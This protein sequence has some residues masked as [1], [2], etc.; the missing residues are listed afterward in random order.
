[1]LDPAIRNFLD[2]RRAGWLKKRINNSTTD[3]E[4]ERI[5]KQAN[6]EYSLNVWL[7]NAAK[8]AKQLSLV[9]H[10]SKFSHP[11]ARTTNII[12][13]GQSKTDGLLRTGNIHTELDVLGNAAA[14]DVYKFLSLKI[15]D[16]NTILHHL[17]NKTDLIKK[18]LDVPTVP[19]SKIEQGLLAIKQ[20]DDQLIQTSDKVKQVYF[21]ITHENEYHLLSI[22]TPSPI[23]FA[24]KERI[25]TMHFSETAKEARENKKNNKHSDDGLSEIYGLS[26][27]GYGGTKPQN[28]S[29]L[30]N[31]NYGEA[32]LLPSLPPS[33]SNRVVHPPRTDFFSESLKPKWFADDFQTFHSLLISDAN[34]IHIRRKRDRT[35]K[36]IISKVVDRL[37]SIR[38]LE[39]GWS[40]SDNYQNLP[41]NQKIW[42]DQKYR[43]T[44]Q[45][46]ISWFDSI[47]SKLSRWFGSAYKEII[48]TKAIPLGDDLVEHIQDII[49]K[50]EGGLI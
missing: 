16:G 22:L 33:L 42:L 26:V 8:R 36:S 14:L 5:E 30:N 9:S 25:R 44:R 38:Y 31:E 29:V 43:E 40:E 11:S 32:L 3:E 24:L 13:N 49:S 50:Y 2:D 20:S 12:A 19:F 45:S 15:E 47:Q 46:D 4:I 39:A 48:G 27:I 34:N 1:M 41:L 21:P 35:I 18:Q 7:P 6:K 28:I 10:P 17:E 37:W 23:M